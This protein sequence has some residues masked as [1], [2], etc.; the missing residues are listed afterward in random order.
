MHGV[1]VA[2]ESIFTLAGCQPGPH[3]VS[4]GTMLPRTLWLCM[5]A[6]L[7]CGCSY[8]NDECI[9]PDCDGY[10]NDGADANGG[11]DAGLSG[12]DAGLPGDDAGAGDDAQHGDTPADCRINPCPQGFYCNLN[13]GECLPGCANDADCT[14]GE[15]CNTVTHECVGACADCLVINEI[16]YDQP[17]TDAAEFIELRNNG[18]APVSL[19]SYVIE[20]INGNG[21][22]VYRT[23]EL[24]AVLLDPAA[25]YV[26]CG[27]AAN[28]PH[29]D[30]DV[31]P[32]TNLIQNGPPDALAL[33]LG[34]EIVDAL[35]YEGDTGT[36]Y[37][38]TSG[39][40]LDD[41]AVDP[42][43]GADIYDMGLSRCPDGSD[44]DNNNADFTFRAITPGTANNCP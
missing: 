11:D 2:Y 14:A 30:L 1:E 16:D 31:S 40:E 7:T 28:V 44:T 10:Q 21:N 35:C 41:L 18:S 8:S 25:Y 20:M 43:S 23:V 36:P 24:P 42:V 13:T 9:P 6:L 4:I 26:I 19:G 32:D 15:A 3:R 27:D 39:S 17:S 22:T 12:D 38:E 33:L 37:T 34:G 5:C 29:C